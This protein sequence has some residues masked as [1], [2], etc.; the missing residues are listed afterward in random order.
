MISKK[1]VTSIDALSAV[2]TVNCLF[3]ACNK[4]IMIAQSKES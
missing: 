1:I 2:N 3:Y 4:G